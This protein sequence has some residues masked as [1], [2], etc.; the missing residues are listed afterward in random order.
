VKKESKQMNGKTVCYIDQHGHHI[1]ARTVKELRAKCGVGHV[2][3]MYVDDALT[4][5]SYHVG[6][7]VGQRWFSAFIPYRK[8]A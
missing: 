2:S 4:H 3:K 5:K 1:Y 6:Y 7:V 8:E